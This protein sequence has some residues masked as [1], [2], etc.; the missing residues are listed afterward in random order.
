MSNTSTFNIVEKIIIAKS[1]NDL[2]EK[3]LTYINNVQ[4]VSDIN[5]SNKYTKVVII[6]GESASK[7]YMSIYGYDKNTT[8]FFNKMKPFTYNAISP[9]NATRHSIAIDFTEATVG[10]WDEFFISPSIVTVLKKSGYYTYWISNQRARGNNDNYIASMAAEANETY[11][12]NETSLNFS[13]IDDVILKKLSALKSSNDAD[14]KEVYFLHLMGSHASYN[15]RYKDIKLHN[16]PENIYEEYEN[17]IFYTDN[18]ISKIYKYFTNFNKSFLLVYFS[19]HG[20]VVSTSQHGHGFSPGHKEEYEVPLVVMSNIENNYLNRLQQEN[21]IINMESF[22]NLLINVLKDSSLKK[23][24]NSYK[25][26]N[27]SP[28][29]IKDYRKLKEYEK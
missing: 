12:L 4:S 7:R 19:D 18:I 5:I 14:R 9:I 16:N 28:Y 22:N 10:N 15:S 23:V 29:N 1:R 21:K 17:S 13:N 8:P 6:I 26:L 20:E 2:F 24:S 11:F 25:I 3:R 27:V